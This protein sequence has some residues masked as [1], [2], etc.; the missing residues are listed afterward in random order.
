M[1]QEIFS[2]MNMMHPM[3]AESGKA[4]PQA[5][6]CPPLDNCPICGEKPDWLASQYELTGESTSSG[7]GGGGGKHGSQ[8]CPTCQACKDWASIEAQF[9]NHDMYANNAPMA[10]GAFGGFDIMSVGAAGAARASTPSSRPS[11]I[12]LAIPEGG[13]IRAPAPVPKPPQ[14]TTMALGEEG[15]PYTT[16]MPESGP[17]QQPTPAPTP[18]PQPPQMTT[19]MVGEEAGPIA[20]PT[21]PAQKVTMAFI[22]SENPAACAQT[23]PIPSQKPT[24]DPYNCACLPANA[25]MKS[26]KGYLSTGDSMFSVF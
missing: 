25:G 11:P 24:V 4:A 10:M 15:N 1:P 22:C 2:Y 26:V 23:R 12:T 19:K 13:P 18:P 14:M 20:T 7:G 16:R 8:V 17:I 3:G 21:P 5:V 9:P 6:Y